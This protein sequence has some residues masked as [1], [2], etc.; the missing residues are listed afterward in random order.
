MSTHTQ[1]VNQRENCELIID[2]LIRSW[3][4]NC[5]MANSSRVNLSQEATHRRRKSSFCRI[6]QKELVD[7]ILANDIEM[8]AC[9]IE[10]FLDYKFDYVLRSILSTR[11]CHK[12]VL[13]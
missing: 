13:D 2:S 10:R 12:L 5:V 6:Y 3:N 4:L 7:E 9:E 1:T 8:K 11:K